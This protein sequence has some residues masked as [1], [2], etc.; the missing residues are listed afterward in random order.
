MKLL[1]RRYLLQNGHAQ[2]A[3]LTPN[4][5]PFF[6]PSPHFLRFA[7][8]FTTFAFLQCSLELLIV[9]SVLPPCCSQWRLVDIGL[10]LTSEMYHGVYHDHKRHAPDIDA[11][12]QRAKDVGVRGLLLTGG[13]LKDSRKVIEMCQ[14]YSTESLRCYC[15]V[16]C[17]PTHCDDFLKDPAGYLDALDALIA[18]HSVHAG[19]CVAAVGEIGLDY[20]RLFFCAQETQR[21]YFTAQLQMAKRHRLPL[22]LH[23]RNTGGD[24]MELLQPHLA[25][26]VGGVVHSFT[27]TASELQTYVDAGLYVGVNGCSLKTEENL[28][29]LKALPLSRLMLETDAPYCDVKNTHASKK[30]LHDA[31]A[32]SLSKRCLSETILANF[33][34]CRK[35]KFVEGSV[36]KG[37][38]EP[39]TLVEVLEVVYELRKGELASIEALAEAV[40]HNTQQLFPFRL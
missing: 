36:V 23:D 20:D 11:V 28:A 5:I 33:P 9:M 7:Y 18:Q 12:L 16:G 19:G 29:V 15:T 3:F 22:F 17:H 40:L 32:Q 13:T 6:P 39:C 24:F 2:P 25:D 26:L 35:E 34:S 37:R 27:G 30:V 14:A 8:T 38:N 31:A 21:A 4:Y 1:L 10:N